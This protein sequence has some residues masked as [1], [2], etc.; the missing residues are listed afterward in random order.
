ML[1]IITVGKINN[2]ALKDL[3][4]EYKKRIERYTVIEIYEINDKK[5]KG[6]ILRNL[7]LTNLE[8]DSWLYECASLYPER[9]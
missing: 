4:T 3:I 2:N 6:Q 8:K 5:Y 9:K 7:F 1:K